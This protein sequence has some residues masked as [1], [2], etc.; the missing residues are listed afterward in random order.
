M[1]SLRRLHDSYN[2]SEK[3]QSVLLLLQLLE[4]RRHRTEFF[5]APHVVNL[6]DLFP[7]ESPICKLLDA[8]D[9][10]K[11]HSREVLERYPLLKDLTIDYFYDSWGSAHEDRLPDVD[12][13]SD[14][15]PNQTHFDLRREK[16]VNYIQLVDRA[17]KL[18][19][20]LNANGNPEEESS[21]EENED[22]EAQAAIG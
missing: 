20:A 4:N 7:P 3:A 14:L 21:P 8:V 16:V 9:A 12:S 11:E 19:E 18:Q 15:K 13:E 22:Q 1:S 6:R 10:V 2:L 5:E 17:L